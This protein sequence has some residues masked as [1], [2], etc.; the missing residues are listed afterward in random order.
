MGILHRGTHSPKRSVSL[1]RWGGGLLFFKMN[2]KMQKVLVPKSL[3]GMIRRHVLGT[4][5]SHNF[6][7]FLLCTLQTVA[8]YFKRRS[9]WSSVGTYIILGVVG[10]LK[11]RYWGEHCLQTEGEMMPVFMWVLIPFLWSPSAGI[12][13]SHLLSF[14][15]SPAHPAPSAVLASSSL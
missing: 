7:L 8:F 12:P 2:K 1:R 15:P 9:G 4:A 6:T 3:K 13:R 5:C 11:K 10:F 14:T